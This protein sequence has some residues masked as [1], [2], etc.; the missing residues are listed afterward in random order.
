MY[1]SSFKRW[2]DIPYL[3]KNTMLDENTC[4]VIYL[5]KAKEAV[6]QSNLP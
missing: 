5:G 3:K 6:R 1:K 4:F 2:S